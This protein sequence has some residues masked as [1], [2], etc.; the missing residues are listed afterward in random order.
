[1]T[2]FF[3]ALAPNSQIAQ[4]W[5]GAFFSLQNAV[6]GV[7]I[8]WKTI[9]KGY[10]WLF[11]MLP[12]SHLFEAITAPQF[13]DLHTNIEIIQGSQIIN[14][15]IRDWYTSYTGWTYGHYWTQMGWALLFL[16]IVQSIAFVGTT[17]IS[18]NKR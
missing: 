6:S 10:R 4:V 15:P 14:V 1:M 5:Q 16:V 8:T 2:M 11:R 18:H 17:Y 7:A 12:A 13:Q 9:P 3:A